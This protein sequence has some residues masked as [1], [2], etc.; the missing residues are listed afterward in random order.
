MSA[1]G[2]VNIVAVDGIEAVGEGE[3]MKVGVAR[4]ARGVYDPVGDGVGNTTACCSQA[5]RK[6]RPRIAMQGVTR[7]NFIPNL[8]PIV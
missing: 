3:L 2:R 6:I 8:S 7:C 1:V 5:V 4:V